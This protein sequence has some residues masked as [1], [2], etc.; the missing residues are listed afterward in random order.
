M[1]TNQSISIIEAA[2]PFSLPGNDIGIVLVH[3][4]GG[5]IADYRDFGQLLHS[6]GYT[7]SGLRLSGHGQGP[8]MLRQTTVEDCLQS[9]KE[10][11]TEIQKTCH[12]VYLLGSSFGGVLSLALGAEQSNI[13]GLIVINTALSYSGAGI[14]QGLLLRFLKLFTP[15][16]PKKGLTEEELRYA[17][18]IGSAVAWPIAGIL[19]TSK[20]AQKVVIPKL[21]AIRIPTLIMYSQ[22]DPVVGVENSKKLQALLKNTSVESA[23][24]P[25]QTHRPFR[26]TKATLFMAHRVHEFIQRFLATRVT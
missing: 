23:E 22:A 16:Y 8:E 4:Y 1:N 14:F 17:K 6:Y 15:D 19:S 24:I 5:S 26:D 7:I 12:Q 20:F 11:V 10:A 18:S 2:K 9:V 3:G 21:S 13:A 25:I